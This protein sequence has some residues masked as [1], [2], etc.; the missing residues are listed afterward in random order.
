MQNLPPANII[1]LGAPKWNGSIGRSGERYPEA[2]PVGDNIYPAIGTWEL[3]ELIAKKQEP[4]V[5][6]HHAHDVGMLIP[7]PNY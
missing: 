2:L 5:N 3:L 7:G 1:M 4:A 6:H